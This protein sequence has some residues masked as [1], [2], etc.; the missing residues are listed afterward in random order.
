AWGMNRNGVRGYL[1][2]RMPTF[3]F[4]PNELQALVNFFM[5]ASDQHQPY[6]PEQLDPIT[7]EEQNLAR[8]LFTSKQ[9]SCLQCHMTGDAAH[10][11]K[12]TAPNFLLAPERLKPSWTRRWIY[13]PQTISPGVNM[14]SEL[15]AKDPVHNRLV[16]KAETPPSFQTYNKD[17]LD[18]IVRYLFNLTPD[19][20]RRIGGA[21]SASQSA[22]SPAAPATPA[23]R[24]A[25]TGTSGH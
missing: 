21:S 15:F 4:S 24:T 16:F 14:P 13:D 22:P 1:K 6:I 19:E 3:H 5:A 7:G 9:A 23:G 2:A 18:L 8:A 20:Q 25:A 11:A 12:A 17:H 10:D